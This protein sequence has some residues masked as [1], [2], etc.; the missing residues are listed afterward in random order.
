MRKDK[1]EIIKTIKEFFYNKEEI[2]FCFV[3]GS[4]V[5]K[6]LYHD[7]DIAIYLRNDFNFKDF[8]KFPYGY[9]SQFQEN[10]SFLLR[11]KVDL[12]IL[13]D[14]D[15]LLQRNIIKNRIIIFEK[16]KSLRV[17]FENS[18]RKKYLDLLPYKKIISDSLKR[19]LEN[20]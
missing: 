10:L 6:E 9:T 8:S 16:D 3:F 2:L 18:I 13:N 12:I 5:Y 4:F 15:L 1:A 17:Q 20:V 19:K 14:A 7:I 11:E